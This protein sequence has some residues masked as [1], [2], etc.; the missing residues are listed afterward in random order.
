MLMSLR[1]V[2]AALIVLAT[3]G[4]VTGTTIERNSKESGHESA[5]TLRAEGRLVEPQVQNGEG[6]QAVHAAKSKSA[7][8]TVVPAPTGARRRVEPKSG[9][10][11][12]EL[13]ATLRAEGNTTETHTARGGENKATHARQASAKKAGRAESS[14]ESATTKAAESQ[15]STG[16]VTLTDETTHKHAELKP[17]GINV[18]AVP[19][20][21]LA[22]LASIALALAAWVRPRVVLL[23]LA[24]GGAMAVFGVLDVREVF[25]QSDES[26]T[27]LAVLAAVIA[28]LHASAAIVAG[29]MARAAR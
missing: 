9:E 7:S 15:T 3:A 29:T 19:F 14:G 28:A 13:A 21:V 25:H 1:L 20:V 26:R 5:A 11:H 8:S 27:G 18:E 23:L 10:S 16:R 22:A 24:I 17:L 6:S 4:F 2:L 12:H